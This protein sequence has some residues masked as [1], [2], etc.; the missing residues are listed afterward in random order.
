MR[1]NTTKAA[2]IAVAIGAASLSMPAFAQ[3]ESEEEF[4]TVPGAITVS[5]GVAVVSDYRFRGVSLTNKDFA[6]QPTLTVSHESGLYVGAWGSNVAPNGGDDVEVDLFAGFSGG[7]GVTYDVGATYYLYP[8]ASGFNY[9]ELAGKLGT[10]IG[11][12]QLGATVAYVPSQNNTGNQDNIYIAGNLGIGIPGTPVS[13]SASLGLEDGAFGNNKVDWSLGATAE[14]E[15]FTLGAS[16]VDT[17]RFIGG[18]GKAG[19]VFSVAYNF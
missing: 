6:F 15:G 17:N 9:I 7:D 14:V 11:P 8:G 3:D 10:T 18:L 12:A 1:N 5:G 2:V 19:V 4:D 13:L 16:Y